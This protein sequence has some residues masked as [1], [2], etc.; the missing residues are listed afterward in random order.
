MAA[1]NN[2]P[3]FPS[4]DLDDEPK[5]IGPR[6]KKWV[7]RLE[8]LFLALD[9]DKPQR[10]K[11]LLLHYAGERVHDIYTTLPTPINVHNGED[12][13][14]DEYNKCCESTPHRIF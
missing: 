5:S 9:I 10:Q 6:W 8:N 2:L 14:V 7:D 13:V 4:F 12:D 11:A 3:L 1:A